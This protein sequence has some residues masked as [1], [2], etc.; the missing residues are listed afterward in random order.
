MKNEETPSRKVWT[1]ATC[2]L[3]EGGTAYAGFLKYKI[4]EERFKS[5]NLEMGSGRKSKRFSKLR[6]ISDGKILSSTYIDRFVKY[7][8]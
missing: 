5:R 4:R 7:A 3:R 2:T 1:I 8:E 6:L